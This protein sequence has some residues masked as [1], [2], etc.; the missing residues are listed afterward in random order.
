MK[1]RILGVDIGGT[2]I[3]FGVVEDGNIIKKYKVPTLHKDNSEQL[4]NYIA[5]ECRKIIDEY[6]VLRVGIGVPGD[7]KDNIV[8]KSGNLPFEN[9]PLAK[10]LSE[11]LGICVNIENDAKCAALGEVTFGEGKS[12]KNLIMLTIGTGIGGCIIANGEIYRG[13]GYAGELGHMIIEK[14]GKECPCGHRG[15]LEQYASATALVAEAEKAALSNKD[16][17]LYKSYEENN[18]VMD[19]KVFFEALSAKCDIAKKVFDSYTDYLAEGLKSI[20]K[21]F[22]PEIVVLSGGITREGDAFLLPIAEKT[23][24]DV[25][26]KVS[27][28]QGD[29]GILGASLV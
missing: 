16:S 7:V 18:D 28:L 29:A 26:V 8:I 17:V 19:G 20:I 2:D 5:S 10:M 12:F 11:R 23:K 1:N 15:C 24:K 6:G 3:K 13:R 9:I 21:V 25:P 27:S 14:D 4:V 22:D